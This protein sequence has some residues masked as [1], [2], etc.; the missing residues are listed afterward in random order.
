M[1]NQM[2]S[3]ILIVEDSPTQ[4]EQ[5]RFI[6]EEKEYSVTAANNGVKALEAIAVEKPDLIISDILMPEMDGYTLCDKVKKNSRDFRYT[7]N[8]AYKSIRS[9]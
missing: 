5:L 1:S 2:K 6:L 3:K 8:V 4:L 7:Y 9:A